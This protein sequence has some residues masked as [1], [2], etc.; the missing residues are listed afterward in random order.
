MAR[1]RMVGTSLRMAEAMRD[2]L[3]ALAAEASEASGRKVT[4]ADVHR[5]L[6]A[7]G[8]RR[9]RSAH[10]YIGRLVPDLQTVDEQEKGPRS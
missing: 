3:D 1:R 10:R 9:A 2:E 4:R 7:E 8:I 5:R 6:T